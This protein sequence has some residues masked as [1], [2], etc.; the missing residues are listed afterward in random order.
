MQLTALKDDILQRWIAAFGDMDK[1]EQ[2]KAAAVRYVYARGECY[3][4]DN[5]DGRQITPDE[6]VFSEPAEDTGYKY[7][8]DEKGRPCYLFYEHQH[9]R[10]AWEGCFLYSEEE[11]RYVEFNRNENTPVKVQRMYMEQGRVAGYQSCMING[12]QLGPVY[13][14]LAPEVMVPQLIQHHALILTVKKYR[15]ED[16]RIAG[17]KS[18]SILPGIGECRSE[19]QYV[20]NEKG[21]LQEISREDDNGHVVFDYV[22]VPEGKTLTDLAD[23]LSLQIADAV[24]AGLQ[25]GDI[26][27]PLAV[28]ELN[29]R[30]VDDYHPL[31]KVLT[32]EEQRRLAGELEGNELMQAMLFSDGEYITLDDT[33]HARLLKAFT[34]EV[35]RSRQYDVADAMMHQ[36]AR[37]LTASRFSG[38][39]PLDDYFFVYAVDWSLSDEDTAGMLRA[40][41]MSGKTFDYWRSRGLFAG[42]E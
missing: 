30:A 3:Q 41:G 35:L 11:A 5:Y 6:E 14:T 22:K 16:G 12:R 23:E 9:N 40:C 15:Y 29:Y 24:I 8:L 34:A 18:L 13:V 31:V 33:A 20:Y 4:L 26:R 17:T 42:E 7:G 2:A 19:Q 36:V 32:A 38:K 28:V 1:I 25:A 39:I 27:E 10:V 37:R 21:D